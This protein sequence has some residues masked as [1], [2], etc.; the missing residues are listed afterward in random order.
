MEERR[1]KMAHSR[2]GLGKYELAVLYNER[3]DLRMVTP[4]GEGADG[5]YIVEG[6][7]CVFNSPTTIRDYWGDEFTELIAPS[8]FDGADMRDVALF[9]NHDDQS[10]PYARTK[11]GNGT[12]ELEVDETGLHIRAELDGDGNEQ[13]KALYSAISRGDVSGMSIAFR[14]AEQRWADLDTEKPTRTIEKIAVLHEVSAV[15]YPAYEATRIDARAEGGGS[16]SPLAEARKAHEALTLEKE[17]AN[18]FRIFAK[19]H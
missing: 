7:A 11:N 4:D 8:A 10:L 19:E 18:T 5:K 9:F 6:Y 14:I 17:K 3:A 16:Y 15:N 12:L 13:A 2:K 1:Q